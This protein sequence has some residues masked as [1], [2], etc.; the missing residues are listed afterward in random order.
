M[1][2]IA[3]L[4]AT[5]NG[6]RWLDE[7][8]RSL[9]QQE[10]V[11]I[12]VFAGDD[13]SS[14][15]SLELLRDYS[16]KFTNFHVVDF[17]APSGSAARNFT[18]LL[19]SIDL[20]KYDY[21]SFCDQDDIWNVDKLNRASKSLASSRCDGYSAPV[22]VFS[23]GKVTGVLNQSPKSRKFDFLFEGAGQGCT[24]VVTTRL[25]QSFVDEINKNPEWSKG[26]YYHD[27]CI[28]ALSR[29]LEYRWY[30]DT[31]P[32]LLYRQHGLNDIGAKS[33][34]KG[35]ASRVS[36][37]KSGWY[38]DRILHIYRLS[39]HVRNSDIDL[40][41]FSE[42]AIRSK[43]TIFGRFAFLTLLALKSRRKLSDRLAVTISEV[44]GYISRSF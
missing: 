44:F 5:H 6:E 36:R 3:V 7:Q 38:S 9:L 2:K 16:S 10:G 32:V 12:D 14:D 18:R 35:I 37:I 39:H 20:E 11:N 28:Y 8:I 30:F 19:N 33:T 4:L 25:A 43:K 27:W 13:A 40:E 22:K 42:M 24:Y 15:K 31:K 34:L 17:P 1:N 23:N 41:R 29:V 21:I 26:P